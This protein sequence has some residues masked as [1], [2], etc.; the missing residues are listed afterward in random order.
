MRKKI[1][2]EYLSFGKTKREIWEKYTGHFTAQA[3]IR[4]TILDAALNSS[5]PAIL[6]MLKY[7]RQADEDNL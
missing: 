6:Q 4:K 5:Q 3:E 1:I 7:F 2:E